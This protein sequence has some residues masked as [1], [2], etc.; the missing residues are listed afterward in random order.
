MEGVTQRLVDF[1][2]DLQFKHL[3]DEVVHEAKRILLDSFGCALAGVS[4]DKGRLSIQL[5]R[6]LGEKPESTIIGIGD[7]VPT[8]SAAFANGELINALDMDLVL[9]PG[10]GHVSPFVIPASLA[11]A[12]STKA[13]GKDLILA[14]VL[15]HE[16]STRLGLSLRGIM[17]YVKEGTAGNVILSEVYGYTFCIFGGTAAVGKLLGLNHNEMSHALGIAGYICPVPT[18][19]K[20]TC[21]P[22][23]AMTKYALAGWLGQAEITAALLAKTGYTGDTSVLDGERGFWKFYA[24][25]RWKPNNLTEKL[26]QQWRILGANYKPYPCCRLMHG[27]LDLFI[28]IIDENRLMPQDIEKVR[29]LLSLLAEEPVW[30]NRQ[31]KSHIDAQFSVP[32]VFAVAAHRVR[33]GADWQDLDTITRPDIQDFMNKVTFDTHPD[34]VKK[35]LEDPLNMLSS[36]EVVAKGNTFTAEKTWAKGDPYPEIARMTDDE[37]IQKFS[38]NACRILSRDKL[39]SVIKLVFELE[40]LADVSELAE[41]LSL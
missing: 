17:R 15:S 36:V 22:P 16:I 38:N 25:D 34:F 20:W 5:A 8:T 27:A 3:P 14:T 28:K 18:M 29:V 23:A 35:M 37:L 19:M 39:D 6:K 4:T 32:Y 33:V 31:I 30:H 26:G 9:I 11:I 2:Q 13:S 12:E 7:K 40:E 1:V 21:S 24:S 10:A 41:C